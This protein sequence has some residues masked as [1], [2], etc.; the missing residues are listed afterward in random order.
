M[1]STAAV[2]CVRGF[3]HASGTTANYLPAFID[4]II[5]DSISST[6]ANLQQNLNQKLELLNAQRIESGLPPFDEKSC[7]FWPKTKQGKPKKDY[8]KLS[9]DELPPRVNL[10]DPNH[11]TKVLGK[12]LYPLTT[13]RKDSGKKILKPMAERLKLHFGKALHQNRHGEQMQLTKG[14]WAT[15]EHE[16][17]N[18]EHCNIRW[19]RFLKAKDPE[20]RVSVTN[21]WMNKEDDGVLYATLHSIYTNFLTP[22]RIEQMHHDFDTQKNEAMNT[23][24]ARLCPKTTTLSRTMIRSDRVAWVVIE[25]SIGGGGL[26]ST[27][28]TKH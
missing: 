26:V 18:H 10:A 7:P 20:S 19:C 16:F 22:H 28:F 14:L 9:T 4:V 1:E 8:G 23:K 5:I 13:Q 27:E 3:F 24:I 12:H 11:C 21:R 2:A 6:W 17:G 25:D 15:L